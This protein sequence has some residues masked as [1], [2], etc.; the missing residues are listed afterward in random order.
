MGITMVAKSSLP[1]DTHM[2]AIDSL[3]VILKTVLTAMLI[4]LLQGFP[5]LFGL[6]YI[7]FTIVFWAVDHSHLRYG[8][9]LDWN[10]PGIRVAV[11]SCIGPVALPLIQLAM[12]RL[13]KLRSCLYKKLYVQC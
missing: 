7:I 8:A 11:A 9:I 2:H 12:W 5:S 13:F 4:R 6:C 1:V 10:A 3:L